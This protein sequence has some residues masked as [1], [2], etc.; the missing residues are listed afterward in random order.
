MTIASGY[1]TEWSRYEQKA[2]FVH[3]I[4]VDGDGNVVYY[5]S[6]DPRGADGFYA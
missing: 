5:R 2:F 3:N 1:P 4:F 6:S